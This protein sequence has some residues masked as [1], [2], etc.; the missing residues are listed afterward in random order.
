M[1][2][3]F[4]PGSPFALLSEAET[5]A[6]YAY[7]KVHLR[8]EYEL[9]RQLRADSGISLADYHVL[10]ALTSEPGGRMR[11]TDLAIRIGWERSRLSHHLGRMR[12]RGLVETGTAADDRRVTEVVLSGAGWETLREAAPDHVAFVREAFLDALGSGEQAQLATLLERVYDTLVERGSLPR[13]S[14][15]P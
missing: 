10:V 2:R 12:D 9:N 8:L 14:D 11:V 4:V 6:W 1:T 7:M 15:H 5:A 13:P 3:D